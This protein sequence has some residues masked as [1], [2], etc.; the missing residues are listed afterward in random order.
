[1]QGEPLLQIRDLNVEFE[2]YGGTVH[3]LNGVN[4][5]VRQGEILGLVGESGSGKSVTSLAIMGLI[6]EPG[7]IKG[8]SIRFDGVDLGTV[9]E[10]Q[11]RR[12]RG[13]EISMIF[14]NPRASLNPL[15]TIAQQ[16]ELVFKVSGITNK[17]EIREKSFEM[18]RK[19]RIADPSRVMRA[20]PHQ[21]SGGMCQRVMIA[22]AL[23]TSPRLLIADE[24]TTGLDVTL[25]VQILHLIQDL[26]QEFGTSCLLITHDLG[27]VAE[28]TDRTAAMYAG[29]VIEV[30][31]TASVFDEPGHHYTRGLIAST[32]RA[33]EYTPLAIVPGLVPDLRQA[34]VGCPFKPRCG[35][36]EDVCGTVAPPK[37]SL[38]PERYAL[39]HFPIWSEPAWQRVAIS[40]RV[41]LE[42]DAVL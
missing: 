8:G 37:V 36:A 29:L 18:L 24:P 31:E 17:N 26:V 1:M 40:D 25:Q 2:T 33:D 4:L 12:L 21:L 15:F 20:Y 34:I 13:T 7:R 23:S 39:C 3:A 14:Q 38:R 27:V 32:L 5:D 35:R 16:L 9:S 6:R 22:M 30:G 42:Q 10:K 19:V 28:Y 11:M 41:V